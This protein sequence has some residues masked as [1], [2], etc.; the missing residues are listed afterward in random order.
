M[1]VSGRRR[2]LP[3]EV[4]YTGREYTRSTNNLNEINLDNDSFK[5]RSRFATGFQA[6]PEG[7]VSDWLNWLAENRSEATDLVDRGLLD[8]RWLNEMWINKNGR[9]YFQQR[10]N[11]FVVVVSPGGMAGLTERAFGRIRLPKEQ[12]IRVAEPGV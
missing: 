4:K 2:P 3:I 8:N 6:S 9:Q 7:D 10:G 11:R 12:L 5:R 1:G